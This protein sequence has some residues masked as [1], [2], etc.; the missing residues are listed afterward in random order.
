[1][2]IRACQSLCLDEDGRKARAHSLKNK[3]RMSLMKAG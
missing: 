2:H 3:K 1:M